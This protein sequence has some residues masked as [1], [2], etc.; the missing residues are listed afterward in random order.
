MFQTILNSLF[1]CGHQRTTFPLTPGRKS[2]G[3]PA[4]GMTRNATATYVVCLDC[5]K[6]FSYDWNHMRVGQPV[7]VRVQVTP[8][9]V[10]AQPS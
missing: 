3:H 5:G 6:E 8:P 4:P 1:G 7:P 2:A 9:L 10:P